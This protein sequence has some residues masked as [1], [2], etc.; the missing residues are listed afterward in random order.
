MQNI[1]KIQITKQKAGRPPIEAEM[2]ME[3]ERYELAKAMKSIQS[4][5][6]FKISARGWCYIL[7]DKAGLSKA[8]FDIAV[9]MIT[10]CR[11]QGF[12]PI[13]FTAEDNS[14]AFSCREWHPDNPEYAATDLTARLIQ[15]TINYNPISFWDK[16][17][18]YIQMLV[19]KIDLVG[20]FE[21]L[22]RKYYIPIANARGW[23]D[24]NQRNNMMQYFSY[25]EKQGK[26]CILL[27]CGDFDID[28]ML[29]SDSAIK[30]M[31]SIQKAVGWKPDR[32][33]VDRFGLN[34]D[35]IDKHNLS[36]INNVKTSSG[37]DYASPSHKDH[38]A[39]HV[40]KWLRTIGAR[41]VEAN[42][43]VVHSEKG[44]ALCE[45]TINKYVSPDA[46]RRFEK[47]IEPYRI[48]LLNQIKIQLD[49][50]DVTKKLLREEIQKA[51]K[52]VTKR[53]KKKVK[54]RRKKKSK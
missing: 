36:W 11:K 34:K 38:Y 6:D 54:K 51:N 12:L 31:E 44:R 25:W 22:C 48:S 41:K 7:E 18:Y 17:K 52:F 19:E 27:Y 20:L 14:R 50:E 2:Q 1:E 13:D 15:S 40:Q 30:N 47:F 24:L 5:I 23:N 28:G 9:I 32:V 26:Q 10:Q 21:P 8:D 45:D 37:K 35:F 39:T 3:E 49:D 42:A 4:T 33:I 46:P 53:K 16:Q 43:L 29:I